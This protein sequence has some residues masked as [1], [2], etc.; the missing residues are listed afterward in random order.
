MFKKVLNEAGNHIPAGKVVQGVKRVYPWACDQC[1]LTVYRCKSTD[2]SEKKCKCQSRKSP[3][4]TIDGITRTLAKWCAT[5]EGVTYS[6][7]RMRFSRRKNGVRDCSD[8]EVLFGYGKTAYSK[9]AVFALKPL[10]ERSFEE[11]FEHYFAQ[12]LGF[13]LLEA[14]RKSYE[15]ATGIYKTRRRESYLTAKGEEFTYMGVSLAEF[16]KDCG[17]SPRIAIEEMRF[18]LDDKTIQS[19][20]KHNLE[21]LLGDTE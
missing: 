2:L 12:N 3:T 4:L 17:N 21:E 15:Q 9:E 14:T 6:N 7:A 18:D 13:P 20:F 11:L 19:F 1:G 16:L 8:E 5:Y 10:S